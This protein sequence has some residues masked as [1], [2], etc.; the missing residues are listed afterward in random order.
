MISITHSESY[1]LSPDAPK[2]MQELI[3]KRM[4]DRYGFCKVEKTKTAIHFYGIGKYSIEE[5]DNE[6]RALSEIDSTEGHGSG[7]PGSD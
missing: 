7:D 3:K 6:G 1:T 2:Y 4:L 5:G